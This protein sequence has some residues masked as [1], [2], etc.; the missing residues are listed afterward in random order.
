M[1]V[2]VLIT[3]IQVQKKNQ[4]VMVDSCHHYLDQKNETQM[5]KRYQS[6]HKTAVALLLPYLIL[7][8]LVTPR[9]MLMFKTVMTAMKKQIIRIVK[10]V[11][12]VIVKIK[13]KKWKKTLL[14]CTSTT[15]V[16]LR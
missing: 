12:V 9:N 14:Y 2:N 10:V 16:L 6:E 5:Y 1:R 15:H 4:I 8:L 13:S 3:L 11:V 7:L